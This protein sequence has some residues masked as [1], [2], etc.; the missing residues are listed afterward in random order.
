MW[1]NGWRLS[2]FFLVEVLNGETTNP[3]ASPKR[4]GKDSFLPEF[5]KHEKRDEGSFAG[6]LICCTR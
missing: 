5:S 6:G 2:T 4:N 3:Y 1:I